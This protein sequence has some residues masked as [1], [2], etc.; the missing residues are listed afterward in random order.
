[1]F[2]VFLRALRHPINYSA[3]R[4]VTTLRF[5]ERV[6]ENENTYSFTFTAT[7]LPNWRAGQHA[8]FTL[9]GKKVTGKTWR[10]FSVASAP[11][12]NTIR[13]G[14]IIPPEPSSF[15]QNLMTL[16]TGDQVRMYGP[17]GE[18]YIRPS[19][20]KVVAV[21]GGIGITPFRAII[22]DMAFVGKDIDFHLIY[23]AKAKHVYKSELEDWKIK[24][25]HLRITYTHTP[26]EVEA[27][28]DKEIVAGNDTYYMLSGAPGMIEALRRSLRER[29]V[30][31]S[32]I[33]HDPFK[34]Y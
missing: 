34:G 33:I 12:E 31:R 2:D 27:E 4:H 28:L 22:A 11:H 10:P 5:K 3:I 16:Q 25:P 21:A 14:T 15:K 30:P 13:I 26:E 8:I 1:M 17:Y 18:L 23:S 24:L 20:K 6:Q 32:R 7:K 9:P 19:M 29:R